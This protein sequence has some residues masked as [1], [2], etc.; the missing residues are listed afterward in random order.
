MS[1][2][3]ALQIVTGIQSASVGAVPAKGICGSTKGFAGILTHNGF[4]HYIGNRFICQYIVIQ[5][6]H[7]TQAEGSHVHIDGGLTDLLAGFSSLANQIYSQLAVVSKGILGVDI[8]DVGI[9]I[10]NLGVRRMQG[11]FGGNTG[12]ADIAKGLTVQL[13]DEL[14]IGAVGGNV[15]DDITIGILTP[16]LHR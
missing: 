9:G 15:A 5:G 3:Q 8:H 12:G 10:A 16:C 11:V 1:G 6:C 7:H 2:S 13:N 4:F 14:G